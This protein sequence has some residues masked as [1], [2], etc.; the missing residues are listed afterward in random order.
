MYTLWPQRPSS[1]ILFWQ[2][3]YFKFSNKK[4]DSISHHALH[5][6]TNEINVL[7][8]K[9]NCLSS[10]LS[11]CAFNH[12][13]LESLFSKKQASHVHA[14]YP[15]HAYVCHNHTHTHIHPKVYKCTHCGRKGYLAKFCYDKMHHINFANKYVWVPYKTNPQGPKKKW[16]PKSP[17]FVF[18]V[19]EGFHKTWEI[20]YLSGGCIWT[21]RTYIW[22]TAI[23]EFGGTTTMFGVSEHSS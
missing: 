20:W 15:H 12:S 18:D 13:R 5:A 21:R 17:P 14:L 6:T 3:A 2:V 22:C 19:G 10:T 11:T 8:N 7:K 4:N 9:I 16:V 23:K 1:K